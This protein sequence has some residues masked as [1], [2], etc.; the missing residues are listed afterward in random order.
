MKLLSDIFVPLIPALVASGLMM[1]LYNVL[2]Q[3]GLFGDDPLISNW[4]AIADLSSM[5]NM[6]ANAVFVFLPIL[7]G[8]SAAKV[9]GANQYLGGVV[10]MIMV[11]PAMV[12]AWAQASV[13]EIPT[14]DLFGW[15]I[16]PD[17]LP[18]HGAARP[19]RSVV[20]VDR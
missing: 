12:N 6:F 2:A 4:P 14:W 7:I 10:G 20:P 8:F 9:F 19:G 3:P 15:Q 17:R 11:H 13:D 5:I 16:E 18:G 1:G